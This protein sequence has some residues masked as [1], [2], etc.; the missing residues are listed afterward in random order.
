MPATRSP[1]TDDG[2]IIA[3]INRECAA[4]I[5]TGNDRSTPA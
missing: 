5:N 3:A 2:I 4:T 1:L